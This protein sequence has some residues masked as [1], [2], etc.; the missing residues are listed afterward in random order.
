MVGIEERNNVEVVGKEGPVL[1]Y[2]NGFG[3]HKGMW[4][5]VRPAFE[6]SHKQVFFDYVGSGDSDLS[7]FSTERY[8]NLTGYRDD[9]IEVCDALGLQ[10]GV[11]LVAHSV[12]CSIGWL[13]SLAS[14]NL[15]SAQISIGPNPCFLN[16]PEE[17]YL[18][19]FNKVELEGLLDLMDKNFLGWADY[20]AP[21]VS[22]ENEDSQATRKLKKSFCSTDPSTAKVF[23]KAT[24]FSDNRPELS[25]VK[26]PN[27]ILQSSKDSLAPLAVG[28]FV[29]S[30]LENSDLKIL[31]VT[32]HSAHMTHPHLVIDAIN[33][34]IK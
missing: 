5:Q 9:I 15:L 28:E 14:P 19:G 26:T 22:G 30:N 11:T 24:F 6:N 7:A 12:S 20:L 4:D 18:G 13:V 17:G 23:A 8:Q 27:L 3:C 2:A 25:L 16:I 34:F 1:L 33:D 32:G 21:V 31:P 10:N 29:H